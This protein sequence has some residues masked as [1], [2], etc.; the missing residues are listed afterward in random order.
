[1]NKLIVTARIEGQ[2]TVGVCLLYS[3]TQASKQSHPLAHRLLNL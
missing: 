1:M 2:G 3:T